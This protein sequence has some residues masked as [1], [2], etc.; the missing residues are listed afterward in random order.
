MIIIGTFLHSI[1]LEQALYKLE[2]IGI[3]RDQLLVVCMESDFKGSTK[4][5]EDRPNSNGVEIGI[6][7]AT[8]LA[9]IGA[10]VGFILPWGPIL[11]G[12]AAVIIGFFLGFGIHTVIRRPILRRHLKKKP[13]VTI[14]VQ[15]SADQSGFVQEVMWINHALT[16][17]LA[18]AYNE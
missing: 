8:A 4:L 16:V 5:K 17:G 18:H 3:V 10:S 13:D 2:S 9:V 15:C 7:C 1:E 14:I 12:L 6:A 11:C